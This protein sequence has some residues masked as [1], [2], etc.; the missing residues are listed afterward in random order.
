MIGDVLK[1]LGLS[2]P[3]AAA[4]IALGGMMVWRFSAVERDLEAAVELLR[5]DHDKL[6]VVSTRVEA[7]AAEIDRLRRAP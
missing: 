7:I 5:L 3:V 1:A 2:G 6:T 4:I